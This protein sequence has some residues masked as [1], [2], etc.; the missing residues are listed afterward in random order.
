VLCKHEAGRNQPFC[1]PHASR[2]AQLFLCLN[3]HTAR[4][5]RP[6]RSHSL[7]KSHVAT[8]VPTCPAGEPQGRGC[9]ACWHCQGEH[10]HSPYL[11]EG[12][13]WA[14]SAL[15]GYL[16]CSLMQGPTAPLANLS[17]PATI[18]ATTSVHAVQQPGLPLGNLSA[19][20]PETAKPQCALKGG[21][22]LACVK[23]VREWFHRQEGS[24]RS[25]RGGRR[26]TGMEASGKE[27]S[28]FAN[29]TAACINFQLA[30][31]EE[32]EGSDVKCLRV[33]F[34]QHQSI[35]ATYQAVDCSVG[36][37]HS[38]NIMIRGAVHH[39]S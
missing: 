19:D 23:T 11:D 22:T 15:A 21:R 36:T 10:L 20:A 25:K 6:P 2:M 39:T 14:G 38:C 29:R 34:A 35:T 4:H 33:C 32:R 12:R 16:P 5:P 28:R 17:A 3:N 24:L 13:F 30:C 8:G 1:V 26:Q 18:S 7:G 9:V 31:R 37:V 27:A